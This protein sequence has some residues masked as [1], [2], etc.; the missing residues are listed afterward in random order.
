MKQMKL[1]LILM[2]LS[3]CGFS[4]IRDTSNIFAKAVPEIFKEN[5]CF[6]KSI[7]LD[8]IYVFIDNSIIDKPAK[9]GNTVF[10]RIES[11]DFLINKLNNR[12]WYYLEYLTA[13]L[14]NGESIEFWVCKV[15][16]KDYIRNVERISPGT[17]ITIT[18]D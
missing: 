15:N 13:K 16:M 10:V 11:Y 2:L 17:K 5:P 1:V 8:T 3:N 7:K 9:L 4:Q 12:T 18:N 6:D 14:E